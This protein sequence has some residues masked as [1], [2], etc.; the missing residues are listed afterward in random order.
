[1]KIK[2]CL[3]I[4]EQ[5]KKYKIIWQQTKIEEMKLVDLYETNKLKYIY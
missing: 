3:Y 1:M 4:I 2:I 5:R